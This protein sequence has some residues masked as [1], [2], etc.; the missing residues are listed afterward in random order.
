MVLWP[1]SKWPL[2]KVFMAVRGLLKSGTG[3]RSKYSAEETEGSTTKILDWLLPLLLLS[4]AMLA[5]FRS[6]I[7]W[8]LELG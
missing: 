1:E 6:E 2:P 5:A 3:L 7:V 8:L 4:L